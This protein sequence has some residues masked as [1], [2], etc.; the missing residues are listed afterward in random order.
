MQSGLTTVVT[1]TKH[2]GLGKAEQEQLHTLPLYIP[3]P[4][5]EWGSEEGQKKKTQDG[6]QQFA[7]FDFLYGG[8]FEYLLD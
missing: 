8:L 2:R 3:E 4:T 6:K 5:D 1:L 7:P